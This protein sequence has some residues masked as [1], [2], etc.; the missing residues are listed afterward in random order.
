MLSRGPYLIKKY[1]ELGL[2]PLPDRRRTKNHFFFSQNYLKITTILLKG[3]AEFIF[4]SNLQKLSVNF[5]LM[6]ILKNNVT[7]KV[8]AHFNNLGQ[9]TFKCSSF[10]NTFNFHNGFVRNLSKFQRSLI[11]RISH[12]L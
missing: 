8:I 6:K 2:E 9:K 11:E 7:K 12:F 1:G 3:N 4:L 5:F 10:C